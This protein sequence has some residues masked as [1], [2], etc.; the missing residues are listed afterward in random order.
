MPTIKIRQAVK[1]RGVNQVE[2]CFCLFIVLVQTSRTTTREVVG[3]FL[4]ILE[5]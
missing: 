3:I 5:N 1:S 2:K 4:L